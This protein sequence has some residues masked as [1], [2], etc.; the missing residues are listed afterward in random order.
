[1]LRALALELR[2]P[3]GFQMPGS[4]FGLDPGWRTPCRVL[5][6][7]GKPW[8]AG[9]RDQAGLWALDPTRRSDTEF[10]PLKVFRPGPLQPPSPN[11]L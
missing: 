6:P 7:S 3:S 4:V 2:G 10:A 1:M 11:E 5:A 8:G 9:G